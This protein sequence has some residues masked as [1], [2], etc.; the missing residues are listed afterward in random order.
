MAS[1]HDGLC[2]EITEDIVEYD[3]IWVIIDR[4]T[5]SAHFL[6]V[7]TTYGAA[8]LAKLYIERIVCLYGVLISIV[9]GR[10]PQFTSWFWRKLQE[11]L[12]TRL[13]FSTA[14]HRKQMVNLSVRFRHL[15]IC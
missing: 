1:Y 14:L 11:E 3:S 5:K 4:L 10:G 7:K 8:R 15:K 12:G 2:S 6:P 13:D 9:S